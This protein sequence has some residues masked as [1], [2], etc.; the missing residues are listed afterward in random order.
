MDI[1]LTGSVAYDFLMQFPG[2]FREQFLPDKLDRISLSFRV[3]AM[4]RQRGGTAP[5]IAYTLALLGGRP[6]VMATV[7]EDFGEYR[8]FLEEAGVD[9]GLMETVEG[10]YTA[11]FFATTDRDN[12]QI[13]S[14]YA[15]AMA[16]AALQSLRLVSPK[17]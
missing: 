16:D 3:D 4:S 5:N 6:R 8:R 17:P 14:F 13:A 9:T 12:A 15:G 1:L 11:S 10:K 2:L 7:G